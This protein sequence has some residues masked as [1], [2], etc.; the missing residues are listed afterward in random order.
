MN[1]ISLLRKDFSIEDIILE[2]EESFIHLKDFL[3]C[4]AK[5]YISDKL[6]AVYGYY[7]DEEYMRGFISLSTSAIR[8]QEKHFSFFS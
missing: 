6:C 3:L 8:I 5:K 2:A 4:D 7:D 1:H